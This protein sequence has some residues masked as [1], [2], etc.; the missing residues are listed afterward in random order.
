M[1]KQKYTCLFCKK[2]YERYPSRVRGKRNFCSVKCRFNHAREVGEYAK[3]N[4]VKYKNGVHC[5]INYCECG[6]EKDYR[7]VRCNGCKLNIRDWFCE[8]SPKRNAS[9]WRYIKKYDLLPWRKCLHCG[10]GWVWN[11][12]KLSLHLDHI[13][14]N[15]NDNRLKNLRVLCPNCHSQTETYASKNRNV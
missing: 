3:E 14:G 9:L 5:N 15:P 2:E 13:N 10:I 8:N 12:E 6:N 4:N 1:P 11:G 7:S